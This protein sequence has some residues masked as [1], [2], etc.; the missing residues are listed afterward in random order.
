MIGDNSRYRADLKKIETTQ[1]LI[2]T[3]NKLDSRN[4]INKLIWLQ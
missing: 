3:R 2:T 1:V 4:Q